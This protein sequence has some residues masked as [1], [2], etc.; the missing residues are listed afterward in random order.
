MPK[1]K[2]TQA[3]ANSWKSTLEAENPGIKFFVTTLEKY[4]K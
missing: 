1:D 2:F 3:I 4:V